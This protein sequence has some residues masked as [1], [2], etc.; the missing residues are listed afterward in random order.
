MF[1]VFRG[2][3][4]CFIE[5]NFLF[6]NLGVICKKIKQSPISDSSDENKDLSKEAKIP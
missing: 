6:S 4:S 2:Q 1:C 5:F 3:I